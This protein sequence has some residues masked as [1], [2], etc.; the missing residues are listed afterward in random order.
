LKTIDRLQRTLRTSMRGTSFGSNSISAPDSRA[1]S[2]S[3][4]ASLPRDFKAQLKKRM[5]Q[6]RPNPRRLPF[7]SGRA[8]VQC[9]LSEVFHLANLSAEVFQRPCVLKTEYKLGTQHDWSTRATA[10]IRP[11]RFP[12]YRA[13]VRSPQ[14]SFDFPCGARAKR[15]PRGGAECRTQFRATEK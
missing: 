7:R 12:K 8:G 1:N 6:A 2:A 14:F 4:S 9:P 10:G 5:A 3:A 15:H 11:G 13:S